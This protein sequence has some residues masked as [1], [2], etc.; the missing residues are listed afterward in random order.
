MPEI[1]KAEVDEF[2]KAAGVVA[3]MASRLSA[4][5]TNSAAAEADAPQSE[6]TAA[7]AMVE[8]AASEATHA[9]TPE[10]ATAAE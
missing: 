3:T 2:A 9:Q 4:M 8:A 1:S 5:L 10:A 6:A 7:E